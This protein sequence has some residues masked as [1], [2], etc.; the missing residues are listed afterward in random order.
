M[1]LIPFDPGITLCFA[2]TINKCQGQ[3]LSY[4]GL[5]LPKP[6]FTHEQL[7]VAVSRVKSKSGLN[8]LILDENEKPSNITKNVVYQEVFGKI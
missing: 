1:N 4:V 6:I 8:I 2:M 7:Y 3:S 5:F